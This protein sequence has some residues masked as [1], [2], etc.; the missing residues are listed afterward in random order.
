MPHRFHSEEDLS[1][2]YRIKFYMEEKE[3]NGTRYRNI[4]YSRQQKQWWVNLLND[5]KWQGR[6]CENRTAAL[7]FLDSI[8]PEEERAPVQWN[9]LFR[10]NGQDWI[11]HNH[12]HMCRFFFKISY[13][14]IGV[15]HQNAVVSTSTLHQ[16]TYVDSI[17]SRVI[18]F[19]RNGNICFNINIFTAE[20]KNK[21]LKTRA[22]HKVVFIGD[23]HDIVSYFLDT[24]RLIPTLEY[25]RNCKELY[26]PHIKKVLSILY[27]TSSHSDPK[28][29]VVGCTD[30]RLQYKNI[31]FSVHREPELHL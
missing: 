11:H 23:I 28:C 5:G 22:D 3:K 18:D 12:E 16:L 20:F 1:T 8:L 15:V 30:C 26:P 27:P 29:C 2:F 9:D 10:L 4:T 24:L 21:Y 17:P 31:K 7:K 14:E 25:N 19:T 13:D 6:R